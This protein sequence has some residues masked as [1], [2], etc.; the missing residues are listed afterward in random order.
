M[1]EALPEIEP[2]HLIKT[3]VAAFDERAAMQGPRR[4]LPVLAVVRLFAS[5]VR[6]RRV[7]R[8]CH[9]AIRFLVDGKVPRTLT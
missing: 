2:G 8:A 3:T 4:D 5:P 6:E 1:S 7:R 9:E